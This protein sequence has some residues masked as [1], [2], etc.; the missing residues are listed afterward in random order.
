[1]RKKI[2]GSNFHSQRH[3]RFPS[4]RHITKRAGRILWS[5]FRLFL[6]VG[7]GFVLMYPLLYMISV[8]FRPVVEL[9]DPSVIWIPKTLTLEN[10][11]PV[12]KAMDFPRSF[13]VTLFLALVCPLFQM[14]SCSLAGYGLARF[15]LPERGLLFVIVLLTIIVPIQTLNIPMYIQFKQFDILGVLKLGGMITGSELRPNLLDS[16]WVYL[17]PSLLGM[18]LKSGLFIFVFRQFFKG[19][20]V[21]LEE[22]ALIDGCGVFRTFLRVMLPISGPSFLT[23]FLFSFVW[24]WNEYY[25]SVMYMSGIQ[26]LATGLASLNQSL[27]IEGVQIFDP[28]EL[29]TRLQSGCFIM[30][31]PLLIV[32]LIMQ[33]YFIEGV[34]RTGITG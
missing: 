17:L 21:E 2:E 27:K 7:L 10:F 25:Y 13:L 8:A 32:Y 1:M 20:P 5:A 33:R 28:F 24:H 6:F 26:T 9:S 4:R 30:I 23:V 15:R 3:L 22:A 12:L 31:V 18:G 34:E 14:A 19:L 29:V 16:I 11:Y